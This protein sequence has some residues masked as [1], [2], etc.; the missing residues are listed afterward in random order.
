MAMVVKD[1]ILVMVVL[2]IQVVG[3][4]ILVQQRVV[5]RQKEFVERMV[6]PEPKM[7]ELHL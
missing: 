5:V 6:K 3:V 1:H 7:E 4:I 2:V